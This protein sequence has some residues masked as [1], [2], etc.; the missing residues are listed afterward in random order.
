MAKRNWDKTLFERYEHVASPSQLVD[1]LDCPRKWWFRRC[2]RL[3]EK[4]DQLK[5]V[6]G[7]CLHDLVQRWLQADDSGRGPDGKPVVLYPE[8]WSE[9]LTPAD[10]ALVRKLF[11]KGV[12]DGMLRRLPG[13]QIEKE[14]VREVVPGVA[15]IGA[16]DLTSPEGVEDQ[17][18]TKSP[19]YISSQD[20]LAADPKML[21]YAYEWLQGMWD[22]IEESR[23]DVAAGLDLDTAVPQVKLRLNYFVKDPD[24][25]ATKAVEAIVPSAKVLEFWEKTA[26]PAH[27]GMLD[28]KRAKIPE[29]EWRKVT[30]PQKKDTCKKYGGCPYAKICGGCQTPAGYAAEIKRANLKKKEPVTV[31]IFKKKPVA[32]AAEQPAPPVVETKPVAPPAPP[33][34]ANPTTNAP[35]AVESCAACKGKGINKQGNPCM[36]CYHI[37][38]RRGEPTVE[39]FETWH[40]EQGNLCWKAKDGAQAPAPA[41]AAVTAPAPTPAPIAAPAAAAAPVE[42]KAPIA[43]EPKAKRQKP[44]KVVAPEIKEPPAPTTVAPKQEAAAASTPVASSVGGF[45]LFI[46]AMPAGGQ[47]VDALQVL[48]AEGRELAEA[49]GVSSYYDLD[50][51]K[52]RDVL[53]AH[54]AEIAIELEGQDVVAIG[55]GQ[56]L[57]ALVEALRPLATEVIQGVF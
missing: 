51:F 23:P 32:P 8:G 57:K 10:A 56:D 42:G 6:F 41:P 31:S 47:F 7:N 16:L 9:G 53:A 30:G 14:Y 49:Q 44:P 13:R 20:E 24:A 50:A 1:Y 27:Q 5:F 11:E 46:N 18:S 19:R 28:L 43:A 26:V 21:S 15:S 37:R 39:A 38:K 2:V 4:S 17:K 52:R 35:W 25:P 3:P 45:R 55:G 48:A 33:S 36:A 40:D 22:Y 54:A 12:A 29:L 34:A